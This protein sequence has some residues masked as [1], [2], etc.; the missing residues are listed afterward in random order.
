MLTLTL[1]IKSPNDTFSPDHTRTS[2]RFY[3]NVWFVA[4]SRL[5]DDEWTRK[6]PNM[7]WNGVPS[8]ALC[9]HLVFSCFPPRVSL[10]LVPC[11]PCFYPA[12]PPTAQI[13]QILSRDVPL[14]G[15]RW[16]WYAII[17]E[18]LTDQGSLSCSRLKQETA[19]GGGFILKIFFCKVM[20]RENHDLIQTSLSPAHL[21]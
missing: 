14:G 19:A 12:S 11:G 16:I 20:T 6:E 2:W 4:A 10:V 3:R 5:I 17:R 21:P 8:L 7:S 15:E 9:S 18:S 1:P 13:I